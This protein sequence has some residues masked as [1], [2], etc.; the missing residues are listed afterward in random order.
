MHDKPVY[1]SDL[2]FL[3]VLLMLLGPKQRNALTNPTTG[4][5]EI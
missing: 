2:D 1:N 4:F 5:Y 3:W